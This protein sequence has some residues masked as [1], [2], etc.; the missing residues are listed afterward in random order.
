MKVQVVLSDNA[1]EFTDWPMKECFTKNNIRVELGSARE[2]HQNGGAERWVRTLK[3]ATRV[4]LKSSG[5]PASFWG[6]AVT[7][8]ME[9]QNELPC[10]ANPGL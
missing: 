7:H 3:E 4:L 6:Y 2:Q 8:A 1:K 9:V 5:L 10:A